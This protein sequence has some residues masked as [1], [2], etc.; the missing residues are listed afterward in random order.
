MGE[1]INAVLFGYGHGSA[2]LYEVFS[3]NTDSR[4]V[5]V[6]EGRS[7]CFLF[8][9]NEFVR[10]NE[11][12]RK[13][14]NRVTK[15]TFPGPLLSRYCLARDLRR[16]GEPVST[17]VA[18]LPGRRPLCET[19]LPETGVQHTTGVT[20]LLLDLKSR[21]IWTWQQC[22]PERIGRSLRSVAMVTDRVDN[23]RRIG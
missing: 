23:D 16:R 5:I 9:R 4:S 18:L 15:R 6:L 21:R 10:C 13:T 3:E 17:K 12:T 22:P 14:K 11:E 1:A 20:R 8:F 2:G 7:V 19:V